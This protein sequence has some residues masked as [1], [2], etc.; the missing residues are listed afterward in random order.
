MVRPDLIM[1]RRGIQEVSKMGEMLKACTQRPGDSAE[2]LSVRLNAN[3]TKSLL[4]GG[5]SSLPSCL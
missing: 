5:Q 4:D 3:E 1:M 2:N